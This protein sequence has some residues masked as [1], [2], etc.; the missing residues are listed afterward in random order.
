MNNFHISRESYLKKI[1][2]YIARMP[3][4]STT[5]IKVLETCND[6]LASAT[7]LKR[8][9]SLDPVLTG[10]VLKL[11]NSAYYS[12]G[13]PISSLTRAII[14]LGVNT[15]KNL[16][17]SYTIL[18]NI[19]GKSPCLSFSTDEFWRHSLCVG[20]VAKSLAALKGVPVLGQEEFF[21]AGLLHDLGKIP[22]HM[23]F[24]E[25]YHRVCEN[26]LGGQQSLYQNETR[27]L[28]V[29][30]G[31]VGNIIAKKWRLGSTLV[32]SLS[33]HHSPG[34]SSDKSSEFVSIVALANQLTLHLNIGNAGDHFIDSPKI[35][36]LM[37][38]VGVDWSILSDIQ[39]TVPDEIERA[40][41]FL[42]VVRNG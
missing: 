10:R 27:I 34:D 26:I 30:H 21:V 23:Q 16:A 3:S 1:Q 9:I 15:V 19:K 38:E 24:P 18:D 41:F 22:L 2:A 20:V 32:E 11:I 31:A 7:D 8:V 40:K 13:K 28:G 35:K 37:G 4:L 36:F 25:E 42:E 29:D 33:Y 17:L 39:G 5:V 6:P 14:M 12:L